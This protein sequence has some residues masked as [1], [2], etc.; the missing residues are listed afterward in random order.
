MP[1][2]R[3]DFLTTG[4]GIGGALMALPARVDACL[5]GT[6]VLQ[7]PKDESHRDTV[8]DGTCQH[9]CETCGTQMFD[10]DDV[11]VVCPS[12]HPTRVRTGRPASTSFICPTCKRQCRRD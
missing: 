2:T 3:R 4:I 6:W 9:E 8:E 7:C 5:Y 11:T 1:K 10:G 12:G